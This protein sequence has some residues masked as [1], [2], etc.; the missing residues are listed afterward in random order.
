[1]RA[2]ALTTISA[3]GQVSVTSGVTLIVSRNTARAGATIT[4]T[5][6]TAVCVLSSGAVTGTAE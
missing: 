4:N 6:T 2:T 1:M 3:T 5:G